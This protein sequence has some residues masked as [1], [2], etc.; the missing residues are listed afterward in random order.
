MDFYG[1]IGEKL[2]H[3][4]SPKIH[5][6]VFELLNIEGAYKLFQIPKDKVSSLGNA[7][8]LLDIK[9]VNVTIPYKRDVMCQLD[10]ISK[11]A[12]DIGA[13][14]TILNK[15]GKL[16]GYNTDYFGFEK[17]LDINGIKTKDKIAVVLGNGG[18]AKAV[19]TYLLDNGV[20]KL[21]LVSRNKNKVNE[22]KENVSLIDYEE[23]KAIKG[24]VLINTTP[25]GMYP[26]I[27]E[28]VVSKEIIKNY[29][30]LVD[31]IYNPRCTE[32]LRIGN[33]LGKKTCDGLYMLVGQGIKSQEIWQDREISSDIINKIYKELENEL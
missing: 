13:V 12:E 16:Y 11:E 1:L 26:N 28:S 8:R 33:E 23:L 32:F 14:N 19:I 10:W 5:K 22:V 29:E 30:A 3:S 17:L 2:S 20:S 7:L 15:N 6:R 21:Y 25:I 4:L 31:L 24:D 27:S 18:A 9:G